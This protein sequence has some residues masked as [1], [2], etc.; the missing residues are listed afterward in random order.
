MAVTAATPPQMSRVSATATL[1]QH[2]I[3]PNTNRRMPSSSSLS[4]SSKN[5]RSRSVT[6]TKRPALVY[7]DAND[8]LILESKQLP[9][10]AP[11]PTSSKA[12]HPNRSPSPRR[13]GSSP[14]S[15]LL[16]DSLS[17]G[18]VSNSA[19]SS[20][21][22]DSSEESGRR[23]GPSVDDDD[24]EDDLE[25]SIEA[26][27]ASAVADEDGGSFF[28]SIAPVLPSSASSKS[29]SSSSGTEIPRSPKTASWLTA[30]SDKQI[31]KNVVRADNDGTGINDDDDEEDEYLRD[32]H[33]QGS[34]SA[35]PTFSS[36]ASAALVIHS[37]TA[38]SPSQKSSSPQQLPSQ[39]NGVSSSLAPSFLIHHVGGGSSGSR[40]SGK[41]KHSAD[42][43][44]STHD[45]DDDDAVFSPSPFPS[46]PRTIPS[47][48]PRVDISDFGIYSAAPSPTPSPVSTPPRNLHV[49]P[50]LSMGLHPHHGFYHSSPSTPTGSK[51]RGSAAAEY[52]RHQHHAGAGGLLT[53]P[54]HLPPLNLPQTPLSLPAVLPEITLT[55]PGA[56]A[57][58][59]GA[60]AA[61]GSSLAPL[62]LLSPAS[63]APPP[64]FGRRHTDPGKNA[65]LVQETASGKSGSSGG[66]LPAPAE[67]GNASNGAPAP[68]PAQ[69]PADGGLPSV[70]SFLGLNGAEDSAELERRLRLL[71]TSGFGVSG[72]DGEQNDDDEDEA[73]DDGS[74]LAGTGKGKNQERIPAF[75][76]VPVGD[77]SSDSQVQP[78]DD[79]V[80][81]RLRKLQGCARPLSYAMGKRARLSLS[82]TVPRRH[83]APTAGPL[84]MTG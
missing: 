22:S 8:V 29:T 15:S 74:P 16:Q 40:S 81:R 21:S 58:A 20:S 80:E 36:N 33:G 38:S 61:A 37:P 77:T 1:S 5:S 19:G 70:P 14:S 78:N 34:S 28:K 23:R 57:G 11:P 31:G 66:L 10:L 41:S 24:D 59:G 46:P 4:A 17:N 27:L 50:P 54:D 6:P 52:S 13:L 43:A 75:P 9:V 76:D 26:E 73:D 83:S 49:L 84:V 62:S 3:H 51:G 25:F 45:G 69:A 48:P 82:R 39:P 35:L 60:G 68:A 63:A 42:T 64:H 65:F 79:E 56:S 67:F 18:P 7:P 47:L 72:E 30:A 44:T 71:S 53:I 32:R 12:L 55:L 2:K